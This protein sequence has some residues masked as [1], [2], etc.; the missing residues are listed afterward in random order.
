MKGCPRVYGG[1][2]SDG[3]RGVAIAGKSVDHGAV[4]A[5]E[6]VEGARCSSFDWVNDVRG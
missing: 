2:A 6:S 5:G 1:I 4:V 3:G